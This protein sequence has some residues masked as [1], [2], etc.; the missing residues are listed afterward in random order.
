MSRPKLPKDAIEFAKKM[1]AEGI[2]S[3]SVKYPDGMEVTWSKSDIVGKPSMTPLEK[4][5]AKQNAAS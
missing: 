4:W 1:V 5:K 2:A 3:G